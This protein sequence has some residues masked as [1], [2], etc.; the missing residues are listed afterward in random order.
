MFFTYLIYLFFTL[1]IKEAYLKVLCVYQ[2][3][4][5]FFI[6]IYVNLEGL[7]TWPI[8]CTST[9]GH[10]IY[11]CTSGYFTYFKILY[12]IQNISKYFRIFHIL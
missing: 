8:K 5:G 6:L 2:Y 11:Q 10:K 9:S 12:V 1:S 4:F 7:I 3:F